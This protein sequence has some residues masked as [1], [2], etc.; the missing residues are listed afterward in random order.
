MPNVIFIEP[1]GSE[2]NASSNWALRR[3]EAGSG[4]RG[5][6]RWMLILYICR[7]IVDVG[8]F[9]KTGAP[10]DDETDVY[11]AFGLTETLVLAARLR[12]QKGLMACV[13]RFQR[14]CKVG[15]DDGSK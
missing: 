9:S 7:E 13:L 2:H 12:C 5:Y 6:L 3:V 1:D 10:D 8:L 15:H 4:H 14:I 11:L